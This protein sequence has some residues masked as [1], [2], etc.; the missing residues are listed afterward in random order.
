MHIALLYVSNMPLIIKPCN[1]FSV[2]VSDWP[3]CEIE[4]IFVCLWLSKGAIVYPLMLLNVNT[5]AN[6]VIIWKFVHVNEVNGSA[7][8]CIFV[9]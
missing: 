1:R 5:Y 9:L 4:S 2:G 8:E 6:S 7:N 3:L